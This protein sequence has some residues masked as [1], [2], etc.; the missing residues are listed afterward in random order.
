MIGAHL[1]NKLFLSVNHS[2]LVDVG[3]VL[4]VTVLL[5]VLPEG[6]LLLPHLSPQLLLYQDVQLNEPHEVELQTS[7]PHLKVLM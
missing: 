5:Q 4:A 6:H 3:G 2:V 7:L 1:H